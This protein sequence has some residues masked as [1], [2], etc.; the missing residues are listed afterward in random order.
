M[1]TVPDIGHVVV[2]GGSGFLG[3]HIVKTLTAEGVQVRVAVRHPDRVGVAERTAQSGTIEAVYADVRD[4]TSV[5]L[6]M[7]GCDAAINSVG[8]Y[9]ERGAST[10]EAIHELGA[11]NVA[12]QCAIKKINRLIHIS[13]IGADLYSLSSYVRARAKGE[14][15][16]SDV[17]PKTTLFRPS[18]LFGPQDKFIN[19]LAT[20]IKRSP[21]VPLFGQGSTKLQTVYVGDVALAALHA[22]R[23][24]RSEGSTY[25]LGGT[26]AYAFKE[27]IELLAA[28]S[29]KRR[30][31]IP[32][33]FSVW[34]F[35]SAAAS[36]LPRPPLSRDQVILM[37]NDNVVSDKTLS[38]EDLGVC[39][40][41]LE[42]ILPQYAI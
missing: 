5:A 23:D 1:A 27:L 12:H 11:L 34:K 3:N 41:A 37:Q 40:T 26:R 10:F 35:A 32:V 30:L 38:L 28:V 36:L 21:V 15:L 33:P 4:E 7:E 19:T 39:A 14:L 42:Q 24:P 17:F 16:A 31:L 20:I 6:A 18:V 22:L 13:G 25:E 9:I 29:G 8:L 2:F